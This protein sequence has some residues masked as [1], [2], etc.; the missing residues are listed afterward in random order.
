MML[1]VRKSGA[2]ILFLGSCATAFASEGGVAPK[3][4]VLLHL[5]PLPITNSMVASWSIAFFLIIAI[6]AA[7]WKPRLIPTAGQAIVEHLVQGVLDLI[8]PIVG[9]RVARPVFPL[10]IGLFTYI[11]I[12]NWSGLLPG[13]ATIKVMENGHWMDL[14]RP[15]D[16]DMNSTFGLAAVSMICWLYFIL[17]YAGPR[18]I[19]YDLFGNKADKADIPAFLY[20]FLFLI[21]FGVGLIEVISIMVRPVSLSFRLFGNMLGGENLMHAMYGLKAWILPVPFYF[22]E[23]L[24]GFVQ[25]LIFTLLIA[26]YIGLITNHGDE[27]H[28]PAQVEELAAPH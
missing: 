18:A 24:V 19:F 22:L 7:T 9:K 17:R 27:E 1:R 26:V 2:F 15:G 21:F 13:V 16:A 8:T 14:I 10:L 3:A 20:Y 25:A 5:G 28:A 23:I 12:Q 6:R 11:L 4:D